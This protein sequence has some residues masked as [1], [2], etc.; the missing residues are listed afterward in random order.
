MTLVTRSG[1][2][3]RVDATNAMRSRQSVPLLVDEPVTV[4]GSYDGSG[5]LFATSVLHAKPSPNGWPS[6]R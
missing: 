3:L 6:D 2:P 1:K 4:R 5:I